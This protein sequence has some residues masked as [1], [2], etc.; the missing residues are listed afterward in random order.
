MQLITGSNIIIL[1]KYNYYMR[2]ER[3]VVV[4]GISSCGDSGGADR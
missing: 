4:R 1:V 3:V 2:L